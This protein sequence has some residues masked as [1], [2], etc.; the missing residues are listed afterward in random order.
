M[1]EGTWLAAVAHL[2]SVREPGV[3]VTLVTVRGHAPRAAGAKLVVSET[4]TWG[5]IGGGKLEAVAID[6][7]RTLLAAGGPTPELFTLALSDKAPYEHGV[8]CCGGTVTVLLESLPVAPVVAVFGVGHVGLELARVLARHDIDLHLIDTRPEQLT[9]DRLAVFSDAVARVHVHRVAV[10]P[11]TVLGELPTGTHA[12]IMTHDHA[13]DLSLCDAMLR[14]G[15]FGTIG[16]IGSA[17][18][19]AR[20]RTELAAQGHDATAIARITTPIGLADIHGKE[21]AT[22]AVSVAA[23][24]LGRMEHHQAMAGDRAPSAARP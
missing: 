16:L 18:K 17:G 9:E 13:E 7:A 10:L 5:S 3:L 8:Q 4:Q 14:G 20:F 1:S 15:E 12:L 24:L 6:R 23:D 21:P 19:W 2:R 22:I 11:E